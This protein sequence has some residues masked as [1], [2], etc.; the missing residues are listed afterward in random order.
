MSVYKS[1]RKFSVFAFPNW[2]LTTTGA[3]GEVELDILSRHFIYGRSNSETGSVQNMMSVDQGSFT[4]YNPMR[5]SRLPFC[6]D[7]NLLHVTSGCF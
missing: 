6:R 1:L 7:V 4:R 5:N 2:F 3:E